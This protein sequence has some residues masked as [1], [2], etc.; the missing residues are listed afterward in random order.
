M[1]LRLDRVASDDETTI[2]ILY[3]EEARECFVLEDEF[4]AKKVW[5]E[6]RIPAGRYELKLRTEG[7]MHE[8]YQKRWP[9][10][11]V[12]ML[13]LQDVPGFRWIQFH[14]GNDDDD[15]AGC[16]LPGAVVTA[17]FTLLDSTKAYL[18]LYK[19]LAPALMRGEQVWVTIRDL[20][21]HTL[22]PAKEAA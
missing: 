15:T 13:H 18:K 5:G 8:R 4:R 12:G 3:L 16:P 17:A 21:R 19:K 2:G 6:T 7:A 1:E 9:H 10:I 14:P 22:D 20:D 11:H